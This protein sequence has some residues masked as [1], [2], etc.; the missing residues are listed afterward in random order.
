[1]AKIAITPLIVLVEFIWYKKRIAFSKVTALTIVS[2][3]VAVATVTD[4]Q[5]SLFGGCVALAWI[6]PSAVNK[7]LWSNV[8][9]Q[10]NWTALALMWKTTPITLVFMVFMIPFLD[11]PGVLAFQWSFFNTSAILISALLGFFLQWSSAL[12]L[13]ATSAI[14]SVV[15]GQFKP[16]VILLGNYYV[17]SSNPGT[18][19]ILGAF[20]A[21]GGMTFYTYLNIR[22]KKQQSRKV[23]P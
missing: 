22:S 13:G 18:T 3:G 16:C 19:S 23:L 9:Q 12:T 17:F 14:S 20:I 21:I 11:T 8:Q 15:L 7:I 10:E 2:I 4:L 1:M 5:F 6:L